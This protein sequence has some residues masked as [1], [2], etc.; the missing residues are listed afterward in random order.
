MNYMKKFGFKPLN[1]IIFPANFTAEQR[2]SY[3]ITALRQEK[4][5]Y[6]KD[7]EEFVWAKNECLKAGYVTEADIA[8]I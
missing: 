6:G 7:S 3:S 8:A 1:F 4:K 2:K 5:E